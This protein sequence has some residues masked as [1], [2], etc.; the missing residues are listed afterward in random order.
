MIALEA[1]LL[2]IQNSFVR[3]SV[4]TTTYPVTE[5]RMRIKYLSIVSDAWE[6]EGKL[7]ECHGGTAR[8]SYYNIKFRITV[9]CSLA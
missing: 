5:A 1:D 3:G 2:S 6:T 4:S 9:A 8:E 7:N